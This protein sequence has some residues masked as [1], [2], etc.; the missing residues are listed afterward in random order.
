[1]FTSIVQWIAAATVVPVVAIFGVLIW[2]SMRTYRFGRLHAALLSE[3]H[4]DLRT[5]VRFPAPLTASERD[6]VQRAYDELCARLDGI[7]PNDIE[8]DERRSYAIASGIHA[9]ANRTFDGPAVARRA[10][11]GI[12]EAVERLTHRIG[13]SAPARVARSWERWTALEEA[14]AVMRALCD[15][16]TGT[17]VALLHRTVVPVG[18]GTSG[19]AIA[20]I[21]GWWLASTSQPDFVSFVG[22][23]SGLGVYAG[24]VATAIRLL[25]ESFDPQWR[26]TSAAAKLVL[27][28][29]LLLTVVMMLLFY[30]GVVPLGA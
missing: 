9:R 14:R 1:M 16:G 15:I 7:N 8:D 20:S 3:V 24:V 23:G 27:A 29:C 18:L 19:G 5:F 11:Q 10:T 30:E 4:K 17:A 28:G 12:E 21:V 6:V 2:L 26:T 25:G 13:I 22:T